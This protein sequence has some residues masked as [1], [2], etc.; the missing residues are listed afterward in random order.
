MPLRATGLSD[1][2]MEMMS[3]SVI[4]GMVFLLNDASFLKRRE[5]SSRTNRKV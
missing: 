4:P 1:L 2:V 3:V 5:S